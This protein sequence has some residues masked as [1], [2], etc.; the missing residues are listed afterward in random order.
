MNF[1]FSQMSDYNETPYAKIMVASI[2]R[3]MPDAT[4]IQASDRH[5]NPVLGINRIIKG[6]YD[7]QRHTLPG[8]WFQHILATGLDTMIHCDTD[9]IFANSIE[10]ALQGDFDVA[11]CKRPPDDATS[12]AYRVLHPY[13]IGFII[14]KTLEFWDLCSG[15][16]HT[17]YKEFTWDLPQHVIGL[18]INSGFFKVKF[19][20]GA[21]YNRTPLTPDERDDN[22]KVWHFK[23][24]R[25][26]WME[27]W[28]KE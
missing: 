18:V 24:N 13:N 3:Y 19:L 15:V 17:W 27:K 10:E 11:I 14:T 9:I 16:M 1:V 21:I 25:K 23:G 12:M 7:Y 22:V 20:D 4:I 5:A 6:D 2:R 8:Y 28:A 26:Q